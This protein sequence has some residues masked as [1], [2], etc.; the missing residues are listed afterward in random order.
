MNL[1]NRFG[2]CLWQGTV[3]R[4]TGTLEPKGPIDTSEKGQQGNFRAT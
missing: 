4:I 3:L 1:G 2:T